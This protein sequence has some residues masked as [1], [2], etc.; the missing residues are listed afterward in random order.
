MPLILSVGKAVPKH[1]INQENVIPFVR[2][3]FLKKYPSIDRLLSV[4]QNG[5]IQSRYLSKELSWYSEDHTFEQK[6]QTYT[7]ISIEL[8]IEAIK[9]CLNNDEFLSSEIPYDEIDGIIFVSSTGISTPTIDAHIANILPFNPTIKRI[10]I[11]GLGCAGGASGLSRAYDFCKAHPSSNILLVAVELCSLTFQKEDLSKSN[12]IGTSLFADGAAAVL[13]IGDESQLKERTIHQSLPS[14]EQTHSTLMPNSLEVMGWDVRNDGLFVIFSRDIPSIVKTWLQPVVSE[15]LLENKLTINDLQ[16][17]IAHPGGKKVLDAYV[18][19]LDLS[20]EKI[21]IS[22]NV[23][24]SFGNMSSCTVLFVLSEFMKIGKTNEYGLLCALG[25][26][27]SS[28][29][30][31]LKWV[32]CE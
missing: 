23:L 18:E 31:L 10:P 12:I 8:S 32:E 2:E 20:V 28:E 14:I 1:K 7:E 16:H 11:W 4:F 22:L 15:F 25:P 17:F 21:S 6:N 5:E 9:N 27:F 24:K 26:G 30:S 13:V 3:L 29:L 19:S